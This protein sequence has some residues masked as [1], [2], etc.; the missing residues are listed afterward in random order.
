M[1]EPVELG[2]NDG[3]VIHE[4]GQGV[5]SIGPKWPPARVSAERIKGFYTPGML[6]TLE[7]FQKD[8]FPSFNEYLVSPLFGEKSEQGFTRVSMRAVVSNEVIMNLPEEYRGFVEAI[9]PL[10]ETQPAF[11][12]HSIV[13]FGANHQ[14]RISDSHLMDENWS[15]LAIALDR[16]PRNPKK[17]LEKIKESAYEFS[18]IE[19]I[20]EP[21][22]G[23]I[24]EVFRLIK[25][26]KYDLKETKKILTDPT[27][28]LGV[29]R[30]EGKIVAVGLAETNEIE[31]GENKLTIVEL[32]EA[33][34]D[35]DHLGKGL[36]L[37]ISTSLLKFLSDKSKSLGF[38]GKELD[39]VFA[40]SNGSAK[41][42]LITA[43]YQNR[44]FATEVCNQMGYPGKGMLPL[45]VP[46]LDPGEEVSEE[47]D[48]NNNLFPTYINIEMLYQLYS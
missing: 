33:S 11:E 37:G 6:D 27:F 26:F 9:I 47:F 40:E 44:T 35:K 25:R 4:P 46:I 15:N 42:V 1:P 34:T 43:V 48:R 22:E 14:D 29:A 23:L 45:H 8:F 24:E 36:Y 30:K 21:D 16:E 41:G 3:A 28:T 38:N 10:K 39:L 18:V 31:I 7:Q 2:P 32:T 17:I 20:G 19:N 5:S 12:N 13:Y